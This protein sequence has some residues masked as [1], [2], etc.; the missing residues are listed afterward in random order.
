MD[1]PR[2]RRLRIL[3]QAIALCCAALLFGSSSLADSPLDAFSSGNFHKGVIAIP[4][5][6]GAAPQPEVTIPALPN[7]C[8]RHVD[9]TVRWNEEED[10]VKVNLRGKGV[11]EQ[12]PTITRTEGVNFFPNQ[13]WPEIKDIVHGRYQF[14]FISAAEELT[15]YYDA[16]T[17][18]LLG[19]ELDFP[20]QP[21]N[22]IAIPIPSAKIV[23]SEFIQPDANGDLDVELTFPYSGVVRGDRP[24]LAHH[25]VGFPFPNLCQGNQY[26]FDLS[27]ARGYI[28][29]PLPA[30]HARPFSDYL[31]NGLIYSITVEPPTPYVDPP[32]DTQF[33]TYGNATTFGGFI[34]DGYTWDIDA[35]FMNLAPPIKPR[36][37]AGACQEYYTGFHTK[38]M[39]FCGP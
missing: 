17:L 28:S 11:L 32:L 7:N 3:G 20:S 37:G 5:F 22:T 23:G 36:P 31:R 29:K 4:L 30:S 14:W 39:N 24:D 2:S 1:Q 33:V 19:S 38:N 10:W 18:D 25:M 12:F 27:T 34:P 35:V 26:R 16:T 8:E 15:F 6:R 9:M 13:F 21:P